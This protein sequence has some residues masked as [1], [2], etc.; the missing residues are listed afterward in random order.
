MPEFDEF[1]D[2]VGGIETPQSGGKHGVLPAVE[3][4][5]EIEFLKEGRE[6]WLL[7]RLTGARI[8]SPILVATRGAILDAG[9]ARFLVLGADKKVKTVIDLTRYGLLVP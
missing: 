1:G 6:K 3:L 8:T 4:K 7:F 2:L 5:C 9:P